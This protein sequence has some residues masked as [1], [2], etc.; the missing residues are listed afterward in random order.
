MTEWVI[1]LRRA[2]KSSK[3]LLR[4]SP[5]VVK[6]YIWK[7]FSF[8]VFNPS[9]GYVWAR[10][11]WDR[12]GYNPP[13][14]NHI[15]SWALKLCFAPVLDLDG[16]SWLQVKPTLAHACDGATAALLFWRQNK[17][18]QFWVS[19]ISFYEKLSLSLNSTPKNWLFGNFMNFGQVSFFSYTGWSNTCAPPP[20]KNLEDFGWKRWRSVKI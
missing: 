10:Q 9:L 12:G 20:Q 16:T 8:L 7:L 2:Q 17:E 18:I 6:D 11:C 4:L 5:P 3:G 13:L 19:K 14:R 15:C 1:I